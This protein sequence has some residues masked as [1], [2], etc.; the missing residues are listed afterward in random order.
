VSALV[1][2][3]AT[4]SNTLRRFT[5]LPVDCATDLI[6]VS[7]GGMTDHPASVSAS[8]RA[9]L[10]S[11]LSARAGKGGPFGGS[12]PVYQAFSRLENALASLPGIQRRPHLRVRASPGQ[13]NWANVPWVAL[14]DD[15]ETNSI[16]RGVYVVFLFRQDM[17]GV[18]VTLNQGVTILKK[19]H[20]TLES[21]Q[22]LRRRARQLEGLLPKDSA[23]RHGFQ[24]GDRIDLHTD[25]ALGRA[26]EHSTAACKLYDKGTIP[27][28]EEI[29]VDLEFLLTAYDTYIDSDLRRVFAA[30]D[31]N[32]SEQP[33]AVAPPS[34]A[35][36][37]DL[38]PA[39]RSDFSL[40]Q[41]MDGLLSYIEEQG[42]VFEPWQVA[43]YVTAVRT[44][45]FVILAGI[46]G[47]GKSKLP[48]LV[49]E[50]T[51]GQAELVPVRPD[52]TDSSEVLGYVDLEGSFRPGRVLEV[53]HTATTEDDLHR[54][55][56][57]DEMNLARVEHYFA[58]VL[59]RIEDRTR[60]STGGWTSSP[61]VQTALQESDAEWG[62][63]RLPPNLALVGTVNMD[64][65]SHGF[66][67]KVL[68]RA[69]TIELSDV[70]LRLWSPGDDRTPG[71]NGS[72]SLSRVTHRDPSTWPVSAWWPRA[73]RLSEL[74]DLTGADRARIDEA[75]R[76]LVAL[77]AVL[78]PAQLQVGYRTRDE[79]ALFLL[80]AEEIRAFFR[81]SGGESVDPMDLALLMKVLPRIAGGSASVRHV[82]LGVLGWAT[83]GTRFVHDEDTRRTMDDWDGQGRPG[84]LPDARFPAV[85]A[86]ACLMWDRLNSEGFTSFWL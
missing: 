60:V 77:N 5:P 78:A 35:Q 17:S 28:D 85:A 13:G 34:T 69:F 64:E 11:Y 67:R 16:Q 76:N 20:G 68:D 73:T 7:E 37:T 58:E 84:R 65:S 30:T 39:P 38:T 83:T 54:T 25:A 79:V 51:G 29:T 6:L 26:Y 42:F 57:I 32:G 23:D 66:S 31:Q 2:Y 4:L 82:L 81:T 18:Y 55:L 8:L 15:R 43:Q 61:L 63:V 71:S 46:T 36:P 47:T 52:W 9:I 59:S 49:E 27:P 1:V 45:P 21:R 22:I 74:K 10:D 41:A 3:N 44:K 19:L 86:R 12:H 40:P 80:H 53:A 75:I 50:A 24:S 56:I 70:A 72:P 62:K 33:D 14:F 48:R